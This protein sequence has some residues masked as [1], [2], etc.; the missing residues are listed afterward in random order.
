MRSVKVMEK[1][2]GKKLNFTL[3]FLNTLVLKELKVLKMMSQSL[4]SSD[5]NNNYR[6]K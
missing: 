3:P 2:L 6:N 5:K 4:N 1:V